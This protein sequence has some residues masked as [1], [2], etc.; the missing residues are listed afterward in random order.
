MCHT[1]KEMGKGETT[2]LTKLP[3]QEC[4]RTFWEKRK[5]TG[6]QE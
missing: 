2:E 1:Y 3:N 6:T 4:I 5:I